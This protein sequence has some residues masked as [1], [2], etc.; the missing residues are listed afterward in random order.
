MRSC[1]WSQVLFQNLV[2]FFLKEF[3][4]RLNARVRRLQEFSQHGFGEMVNAALAL[5]LAHRFFPIIISNKNTPAAIAIVVFE[6]PGIIPAP[7][8]VLGKH[9]PVP[10]VATPG[11]I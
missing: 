5:F 10:T 1:S 9:F 2:N 4:A 8:T 7:A 3:A 11:A 6:T